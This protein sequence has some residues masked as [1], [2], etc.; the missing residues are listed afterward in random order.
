M[1]H[2]N[3]TFFL[4]SVL[5]F[6]SQAME[7]ELPLS[8]RQ[9]KKMACIQKNFPQSLLG[10]SYEELKDYNSNIRYMAPHSL[11]SLAL[12]EENND[13][14]IKLMNKHA[15]HINDP[16]F[17][18][19][20]GA[21][22]NKNLI[23]HL[24]SLQEIL[25]PSKFDIAIAMLNFRFSPRTLSTVKELITQYNTPVK[26]DGLSLVEVMIVKYISWENSYETSQQYAKVVDSFD[27]KNPKKTPI[28]SYKIPFKNPLPENE[29]RIFSYFEAIAMA[30]GSPFRYKNINKNELAVA[31]C[32]C[33]NAAA[34]ILGK[35]YGNPS[36]PKYPNNQ[37]ICP[38]EALI[39]YMPMPL[40]CL[41]KTP[42]P[43]CKIAII[44]ESLEKNNIIPRRKEAVES[45][46]FELFEEYPD[47][48]YNAISHIQQMY[49]GNQIC[50]MS[51]TVSTTS[52][53]Q[54]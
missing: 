49:A 10:M 42:V 13:F 12:S 34:K 29:Q 6:F 35:E 41:S 7:K 19:F 37:I 31:F 18:L 16:F 28:Y 32:T 25:P 45:Q 40:H 51:D 52:G 11:E 36:N 8:S 48:D 54:K 1:Q 23:F 15:Q 46:L 27:E 50:V 39:N 30:P 44:V 14:F 38:Y 22:Y 2:K 26:K 4:F 21:T 9:R 3:K 24:C 17:T 20:G 47:F 43:P 33:L 53:N 5:T